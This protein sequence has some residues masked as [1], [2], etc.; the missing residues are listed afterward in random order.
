M[1][2]LAGAEAWAA[3]ETHVSRETNEAMMVDLTPLYE[4][5]LT[6]AV[7]PVNRGFSSVI[8]ATVHAT[9]Y[10]MGRDPALR[11]LIRHHA[12][13]IRRCGG[14]REMEALALLQTHLPKE[15]ILP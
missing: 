1:Q 11:E 6:C 10:V 5:M 13:I 8:E 7:H 2:R 4:Q 12:S 15:T 14:R 9:R 3:F